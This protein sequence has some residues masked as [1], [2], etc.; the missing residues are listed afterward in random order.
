MGVANQSGSSAITS[1]LMMELESE[2]ESDRQRHEKDSAKQCCSLAELTA[3]RLELSDKAKGPLPF[4]APASSCFSK[5][6]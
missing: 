3:S 2:R 5:S 6:R 4:T 1:A